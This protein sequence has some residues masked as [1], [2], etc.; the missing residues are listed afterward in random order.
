MRDIVL[1]TNSELIAKWEAEDKTQKILVFSQFTSFLSLIALDLDRRNIPHVSYLGSHSQK[2]REEAVKDFT[3]PTSS[4]DS[5]RVM[6]ISLKAGGVGLNLTVANRVC[7][8]VSYFR[9][10]LLIISLQPLNTEKAF[11][12]F[13]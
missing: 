10:S 5:P 13:L 11:P 12:P 8:S 9:S 4:R 1:T 2:T 3:T 6:L 7:L